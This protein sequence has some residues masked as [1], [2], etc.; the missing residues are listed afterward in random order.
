MEVMPPHYLRDAG[1]NTHGLGTASTIQS[2][3]LPQKEW[4]NWDKELRKSDKKRKKN[5]IGFR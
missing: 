3:S 2:R 5:P 1:Y 4:E